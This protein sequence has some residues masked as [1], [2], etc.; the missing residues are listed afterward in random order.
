MA[1]YSADIEIAVRGAQQVDGLIK[2]INRLNNSI[3][4]VNK[5]AQLLRGKGFNVASIEN[6]SR[7]VSKA[8]RALRKAAQ[9]TRQEE[10]A[11]R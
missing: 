5:N 7:A 10:D 1:K 6:Y 8:E 2:H 3:N 4:V 9:G 11:V